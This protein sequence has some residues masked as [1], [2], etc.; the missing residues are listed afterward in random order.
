MNLQ[1]RHIFTLAAVAALSTSAVY[2][3]AHGVMGT[4]TLPFQAKRGTAL[5]QPGDYTLNAPQPI[6][7]VQLIEISREGRA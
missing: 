6:N 5:L 4:F 2:A 3:Q 7:G 1:K